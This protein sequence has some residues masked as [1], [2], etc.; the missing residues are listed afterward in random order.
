MPKGGFYFMNWISSPVKKVIAVLAGIMTGAFCTAVNYTI[1]DF[2]F[3]AAMQRAQYHATMKPYA[4]VVFILI[5]SVSYLIF[6]SIKRRNP[7]YAY[8]FFTASVLLNT[9]LLFILW[10]VNFYISI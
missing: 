9:A 4:A 5:I 7:F 2:I 8:G 10:S 3:S 1:S 6:I